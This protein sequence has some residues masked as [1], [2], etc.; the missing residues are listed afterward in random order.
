MYIDMDSMRRLRRAAWLSCF[1]S[2]T[3]QAPA[4]N[5]TARLIL[6]DSMVKPG[7]TV[8]AGVALKMNPGWHTYWRNS[9]D[10]GKPTEIKWTLP[11]GVTAGAVNWPVPEKN[12]TVGLTTYVYH[13]DAVLL[14][15]LTVPATASPGML[16][17]KARIEFLECDV[18]SSCIPG[19][20]N[21][22]ATLTIGNESKP[23]RDATVFEDWRKKLPQVLTNSTARTWWESPGTDDSRPLIIEWDATESA[24]EADFFPYASEQFEV[25]GA[26]ERVKSPEGKIQIRKLVKKLEGDWP[27]TLSGVLL[28]RTGKDAPLAAFE[29]KLAI[30]KTPVQQRAAA[31]LRSILPM[32]G[33]AFLGGL[34]LNIMPCVLPVIALKV[35][36]F[37]NQAKETPQ[38][39][40]RLG[41]VYGAGVL[42]S[43]LVLAGIAIGVQQAGGLAGWSTAFQNPQFRVLITVLMTL[44]ALNLFGVFEIT[45]S[46]GAMGA[47]SQ[48]T[49][50][51]GGAGAFFNGVLATV[52]ATPCTAPFL[53]VAIGFAFTQPPL[54][55]VLM[56]IAVG[57]GLAAPFVALCWQPG[58]LKFLPKP[59][60]WMERFKVAMG[61]PMLATAMWL[62]WLTGTRLGKTGVLWLGL[63]LIVLALAA[64]VFGEFVQRGTRRRGLAV[65][66]CLGFVAIGYGA[67]L[68][69][70]LQWRAPLAKAK[71]GI[72]WKTWS[73]EA[74][75][76]ARHEGHP[77]L[78]DFTADTCLNCQLNK[79]TSLEIEATRARLKAIDAVPFLADFTDE[80]PAIARELQ[81]YG[82]AGVPLV[83]VYPKD[84]S[85]PPIV[86]PAVLTPSI[87]LE[88]LD[89]AAN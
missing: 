89:R 27:T 28:S 58:W 74:V 71:G 66:I 19:K 84:A 79:I 7:Q 72:D 48:L 31:P 73:P 25:S 49:A 16:E 81:R 22:S 54:I 45:L 13:D 51:E 80:N 69:K 40:R 29:A 33:F 32:L 52:L 86:L 77:V 88:A 82:R 55:V 11:T 75:E 35:L 37:V 63:F 15:P 14:V 57:L 47:A 41:L 43:F 9:G 59:G 46:G 3:L 36:G 17:L 56:F 12:I 21:V 8:W 87:V 44:V 1:L 4:A 10:S 83:L 64:W 68:E 34:I 76:K 85:K 67:I 2:A 62:F 20:A 65:A 5:T 38:R 70:Q 24:V 23:S 61:F 18:A 60:A 50:K 26:T 42:V 30:G 6:S 53:G 39:V 78:V